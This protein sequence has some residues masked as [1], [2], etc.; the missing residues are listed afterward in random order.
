MT[1]KRRRGEEIE[2]AK[3]VYYTELGRGVA[4]IQSD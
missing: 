4:K 3:G 1:I 2:L